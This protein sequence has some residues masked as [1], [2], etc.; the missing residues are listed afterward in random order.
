MI[1]SDLSWAQAVST[2]VPVLEESNRNLVEMKQ[3]S[4]KYHYF[5]MEVAPGKREAICFSVHLGL[6]H[7]KENS[8]VVAMGWEKMGGCCSMGIVSITQDEN[9]LETCYIT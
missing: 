9:V 6:E 7:K 8:I 1:A 5:L 3:I 2:V 4:D